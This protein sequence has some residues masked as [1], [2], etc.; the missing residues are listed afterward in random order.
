MF[1]HMHIKRVFLSK[2][3]IANFTGIRFVPSVN[4]LVCQAVK[5]AAKNLVA[6]SAG[7]GD[8]AVDTPYMD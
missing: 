1:L 3:Y 2:S 4:I 8:V 6:V 7:E 5:V